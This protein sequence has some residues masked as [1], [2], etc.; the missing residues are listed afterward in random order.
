MLG[1]LAAY[2]R[3]SADAAWLGDRGN[4]TAPAGRTA[5]LEPIRLVGWASVASTVAWSVAPFVGACRFG[6]RWGTGL[7]AL[8]ALPLGI[9]AWHLGRQSEADKERWSQG[10]L[11]FGPV[12]AWVYLITKHKAST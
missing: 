11:R 7:L 4:V 5:R 1:R 9:A 2:P 6:T 10:L 8:L 3:C 12:A